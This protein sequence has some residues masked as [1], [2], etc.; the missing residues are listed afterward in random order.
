MLEVMTIGDFLSLPTQQQ[1]E[2]QKALKVK[3]RLEQYLLGLNQVA[4]APVTPES[5]WKKCKFCKPDAPGVCGRCHPDHAGWQLVEMRNNSD[6]HPSQI[7]KCIKLLWFFCNPDTVN[8][9]EEFIDARL[10]MI[11]DLGHAWHHMMQSYGK[12]GAWS[13]P[14][15]YHP[16]LPIDPDE[17]VNGQLKLPVANDFWIRGSADAVIDRYILPNV[18]TIGDVVVRMV[19]EYKT[20][21]STQFAKLIR[22]KSEHKWQ[23]TMYSAV[24]NVPFVVYLYMNKDNCQVADFPVAFDHSIWQEIQN[25]IRKVQYYT[26][27]GAPPPWEETAAVLNPMECKNCGFN[28]I[29]QPPSFSRRT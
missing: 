12:N 27:Q 25:R 5:A 8:Q 7:H 14:Q 26:D 17:E 24:F 28:K 29:C 20:I 22:P 19:H 6:I 3:D 4:A 16:E 13:E 9:G 18:P 1:Q 21:N 23:A 15:H 10:R 2:I 11:F